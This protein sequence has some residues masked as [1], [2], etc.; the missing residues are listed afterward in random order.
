MAEP[1]PTLAPESTWPPRPRALTPRGVWMVVGVLIFAVAMAAA[2]VYLRRTR[3]EKT[4]A[5]WG[6]ATIRAL[7]SG[8]TLRMVLPADSPLLEKAA[9]GGEVPGGGELRGDKIVTDLSGTPG[10]GHFR[11][12]LLDER[13]YDWATE[14]PVGIDRVGV[15]A[16]EYVTIEIEGPPADIV[17]SQLRI[18]LSEGWAGPPGGDKS[19]RLTDRVRSAVRHFLITVQDMQTAP[20]P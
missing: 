17:A 19:V 18:E 9:S 13:H 3:L 15:E 4:R 16:A 10:L 2:S 7:Q 14:Q 1:E 8:E 12:A 20:T 6:P 11:H 5:F